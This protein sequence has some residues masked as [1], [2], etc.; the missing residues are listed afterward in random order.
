MPYNLT[1]IKT[2]LQMACGDTPPPYSPGNQGRG[3]KV[4][5]RNQAVR[6][7]LK[8]GKSTVCPRE[9]PR[10]RVPGTTT[11]HC[12][13]MGRATRKST[14]G[15]LSLHGELHTALWGRRQ[16]HK[17]DQIQ[18]HK[19]WVSDPRSTLPPMWAS[20]SRVPM[21]PMARTQ[22]RGRGFCLRR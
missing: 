10:S 12:P 3:S 1:K 20:L 11:L 22:E 17:G 8:S 7:S 9:E 21:S 4:K 18:T 6:D 2:S 5:I 13:R 14:E 15:P 19:T 16:P